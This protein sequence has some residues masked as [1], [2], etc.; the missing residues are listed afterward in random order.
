VTWLAVLW[1]VLGVLIEAGP[2][3]SLVG[4]AVAVGLLAAAFLAAQELRQVHP[5]GESVT[6]RGLRAR[7]ERIGV[8]RHRDPDAAG[9]ARPRAPTTAVHAAA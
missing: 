4:T 3:G 7:A 5:G 2:A 8:P 1:R 9:H 6:R